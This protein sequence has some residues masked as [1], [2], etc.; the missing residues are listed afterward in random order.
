[1]S[2]SLAPIPTRHGAAPTRRVLAMFPGQGAQRPGMA[3]WL[4]E[5]HP[6]AARLFALADEVLDMPLTELCTFADAEQLT[7]TEIA[8]PAV[9]V[10]SLAIYEVLR[11]AGVEP[12]IVAGHSLGEFP[13]LVAAGVL[14]PVD[15]LRLVGVRGRLMAEVARRTPGAMIA[16]SGL[17]VHLLEDICADVN[18]VV[19]IANHNEP[20]QS[21]LSGERRAVLD[22]ARA[23]RFAGADRTVE[24][25]VGAP[26]HC[27]LMREIED[28]FASATADVVFADPVLPLISSVTAT[29]VEGGQQARELLR[30][31]PAA[32][33][34][35]VDV[36]T[37][38]DGMGVTD[39]LEV[40]PGRVL[41]GLVGRTVS[42]ATVRST[43]DSRRLTAVTRAYR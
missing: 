17:A 40:G 33:V 20:L 32:R 7:P 12:H 24:L 19:E 6:E 4:I 11:T 22:A 3:A 25:R 34:R 39:Y 28:E 10:T 36:L 1:M 41:S 31:Q 37:T 15:A 21:V 38:A 14:H 23:A 5:R 9:A 8:Q 18:G 27:S 30:G 43:N 2:S 16:V 26:F 29:V 42:A 35:W 13:A